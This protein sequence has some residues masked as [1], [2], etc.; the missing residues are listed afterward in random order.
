VRL[1]VVLLA[2][3]CAPM[4]EDS[5]V[6]R[7]ETSACEPTVGQGLAGFFASVLGQVRNCYG[8]QV[9]R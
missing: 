8:R 5:V 2:N 6:T 9:S 1:V 3:K 7:G 4:N